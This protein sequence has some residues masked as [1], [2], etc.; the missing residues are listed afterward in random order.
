MHELMSDEEFGPPTRL[1]GWFEN[2]QSEP[3]ASIQRTTFIR[4]VD[5]PRRQLPQFYLT[6]TARPA[7]PNP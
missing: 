4:G 5:E 7:S 1:Q 6:K 2:D 3:L